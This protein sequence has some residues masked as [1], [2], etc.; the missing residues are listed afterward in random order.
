MKPIIKF[1]GGL[2]AILCN[3]C[4]VIIKSNLTKKEFEG[5]TKLLLCEKCKKLKKINGNRRKKT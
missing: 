1:N 4:R 5:K 3:N 2:G